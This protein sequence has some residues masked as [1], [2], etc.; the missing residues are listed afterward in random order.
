M[1]GHNIK[2]NGKWFKAGSEIPALS[3]P[4]VHEEISEPIESTQE[5]YT[6]TDINRMP[7][8]ELRNLCASRG[9]KS[10]ELSGAEMKKLLINK[11]GL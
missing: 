8:A 4:K 2:I 9:I 10:D 1:I 3:V 11:L 7:V 5:E 6:R